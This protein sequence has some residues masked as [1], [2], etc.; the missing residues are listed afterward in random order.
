[1]DKGYV[2]ATL[3]AHQR[4]LRAAGVVHLRLFGSLARGENSP[5]SDVDLLAEFDPS[6]RL[7]LLT[8]SRLE[9]RLA[10]LLGVEVDLSSAEWM[11]EPV[12]SKALSEAVLA[13]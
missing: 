5:N 9:N 10:D 3:Q 1:M 7:S 6:E 2:I 12:R 8:M 11:R 4:E 13:F